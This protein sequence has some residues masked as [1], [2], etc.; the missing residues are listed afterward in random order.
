M[1]LMEDLGATPLYLRRSR[2]LVD[3]DGRDPDRSPSAFDYVFPL[4]RPLQ[5]VVSIELVG[6]A[7]DARSWSPTWLGRYASLTPGEDG[8]D[9]PRRRAEA[10]STY[11]VRL[12]HEGSGAQVDF[13]VD[14][15]VTGAGS[16]CGSVV[17]TPAEFAELLGAAA[18]AAFEALGTAYAPINHTNTTLAVGVDAAGRLTLLAHQSGTPL[19][20]RLLFGSGPS[21]SQQAAKAAGFAP[22]VDTATPAASN[23]LLVGDY[24]IHLQPHRYLDVSLDRE[25]PEQRPHARVFLDYAPDPGLYRRPRDPGHGTRLL[26]QPV[27]TLRDLQVRLSLPD[28]KPVPAGAR[29]R[30]TLEFEVLSLAPLPAAASWLEQTLVA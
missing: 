18:Q 4:P 14:M 30:H 15:E 25:A 17:A 3:P 24:R 21:R 13:S 7:F 23:R 1:P 5:R 16:W 9:A 20:P 8:D 2:L 12:E 22:G 28:G 6:W 19:V 11:D 29:E 10:A 27:R 26:Q